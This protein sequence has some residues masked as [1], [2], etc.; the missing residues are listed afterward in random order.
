MKEAFLFPGRRGPL[1]HPGGF[2]CAP[3]AL[4]ARRA[5]LARRARHGHRHSGRGRDHARLRRPHRL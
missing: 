4:A 2:Q 3:G 1:H 5:R